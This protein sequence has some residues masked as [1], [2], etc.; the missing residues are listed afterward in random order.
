MCWFVLHNNRFVPRANSTYTI[1][2][3]RKTR[4]LFLYFHFKKATKCVA[5]SIADIY[6]INPQLCNGLVRTFD[7]R[8]V[9]MISAD[10]LTHH[11]TVS[12]LLAVDF[13][14]LKKLYIITADSFCLR[15]EQFNNILEALRTSDVKSCIPLYLCFLVH[16]F[17]TTLF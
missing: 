17:I 8:Y 1:A 11:N 3:C 14:L 13:L 15:W 16:T 10:M 9:V 5:L 12:P 2:K 6:S 4:V 7:A